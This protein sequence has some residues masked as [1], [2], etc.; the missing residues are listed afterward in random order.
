MW[1]KCVIKSCTTVTPP[2]MFRILNQD[3][4]R[5]STKHAW[6]KKKVYKILVKNSEEKIA[7]ETTG[8]R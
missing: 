8:H 3:G 7:P 2:N 1:M 4:G 6:K 5:V